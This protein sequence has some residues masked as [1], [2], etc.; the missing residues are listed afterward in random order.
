MGMPN[1]PSDI[2][3][4]IK[5]DHKG[6]VKLLLMSIALEELSLSH[7]LNAQ[8]D[9]MQKYLKSLRCYPCIQYIDIIKYNRTVAETLRVL[10]EKEKTLREKMIRIIEYDQDS[11]PSP[12]CNC[13]FHTK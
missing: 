3:T 8:G 6:L 2:S 5:I 9:M 1:L 11:Q 12:Y 7:I 4:T 13:G 10:L